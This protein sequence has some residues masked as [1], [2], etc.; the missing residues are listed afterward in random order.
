MSY[1]LNSSDN[2]HNKVGKQWVVIYGHV[3]FSSSMKRGGTKEDV[4]TLYPT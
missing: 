3:I 1:M 2:E 4:W